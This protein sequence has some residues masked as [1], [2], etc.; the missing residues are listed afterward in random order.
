MCWPAWS[1]RALALLAWAAVLGWGVAAEQA[2]YAGVDVRDWLPDLVTGLVVS[3]AGLYAVHRADS[4]CGLLVALSGVLWFLPNFSTMA[5][6]FGALAGQLLFLYR[7]PLV[8]LLIVFPTGRFASTTER[9]AAVAGYLIALDPR[10]WGG[11]PGTTVASAALVVLVVRSVRRAP[12]RYRRARWLAVQVTVVLGAMLVGT[13]AVRSTALAGTLVHPTQIAFEVVYAAIAVVLVAALRAKTWGRASVTDL[14]LDLGDRGGGSLRD[15]LAWTLADPSL[16]L[17]FAEAP[18]VED[19]VGTELTVVERAGDPVATIVHRPGLL[20]DP[21]VH[22]AVAAAVRLGVENALLQRELEA[23]VHEVVAS[24]RRLLTAAD[25]EAARL[26]QRLTAGPLS[27]LARLDGALADPAVAEVLTACVDDLRQLAHGLHPRVLRQRGL[28]AGVRELARRCPIPVEIDTDSVQAPAVAETT[29]YFVC[30]EAL[31]NVV[32]HA[33]ASVVRVSLSTDDGALLLEVRDD[34]SGGADPAGS[35]LRGLT[36]RLEA[37]GGALW[38][39]SPAGAGTLVRAL[40]P[41]ELDHEPDAD[42]A[43]DT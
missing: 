3:G 28:V 31:A 38:V 8:H 1:G 19:P 2:A 42:A 11:A 18:A 17:S 16:R 26:E 32:K 14:V 40:I 34:G 33:H 41:T 25:D 43:R 12:G 22:D 13:T 9:L 21:N 20:A 4:R 35:G 37:L 30:S 10:V 5:G 15:A 36:D 7:G 23:R 27:G 39:D 6:P 24:R 29:A